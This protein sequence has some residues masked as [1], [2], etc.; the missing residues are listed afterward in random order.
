MGL[1][2]RSNDLTIVFILDMGVYFGFFGYAT[3]GLN[4]Q[5]FLVIGSVSFSVFLNLIFRSSTLL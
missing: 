3:T 2:I 5:L 4:I 1:L